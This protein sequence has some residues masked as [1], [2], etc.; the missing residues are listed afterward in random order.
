MQRSVTGRVAACRACSLRQAGVLAKVPVHAGRGRVG[1]EP[2]LPTDSSSR[3]F[4]ARSSCSTRG[5]RRRSMSDTT[6]SDF[7]AW[8]R[9]RVRSDDSSVG[10]VGGRI[11]VPRV[12]QLALFDRVPRR[13][14]RFSRTNIYARDRNTCQYCGRR[15]TRAEFSIS[16]TWSRARR[17]AKRLGREDVACSC[18]SATGAKE[19]ARRVRRACDSSAR[20]R[21]RAGHRS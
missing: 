16:T 8:R 9:E 3:P 18:V 4:A 11:R 6:R 17:G 20:G 2:V 21:V 1:A 19:V 14:V 12:I 10:T 5:S 13:H 15:K 7:E